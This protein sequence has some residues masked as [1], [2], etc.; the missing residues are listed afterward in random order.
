MAARN[1]DSFDYRIKPGVTVDREVWEKF[2]EAAGENAS[3]TLENLMRVYNSMASTGTAGSIEVI[4]SQNLASVSLE[5]PDQWSVNYC[6]GALNLTNT[7]PS[8]SVTGSTAVSPKSK[9]QNNNSG[10][11]RTI[12]IK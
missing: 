1:S 11:V 6:A 4:S 12:I 9:T 5:N 10:D 8:F 2:K 3:Q 7:T